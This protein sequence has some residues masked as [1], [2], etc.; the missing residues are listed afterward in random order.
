MHL[1]LYKYCTVQDTIF[2]F[3]LILVLACQ[4][5]APYSGFTPGTPVFTHLPLLG[6]GITPHEMPM[7]YNNKI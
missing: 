4:P 7:T 5:F 6:G 1:N 3:V 2:V